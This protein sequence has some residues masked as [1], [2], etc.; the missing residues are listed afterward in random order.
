MTTF[1]IIITILAVLGLV[2]TVLILRGIEQIQSW[3]KSIWQELRSICVN[4]ADT[5]EYTHNHIAP[6]V[7]I[8]SNN[9]LHLIEQA[10]GVA[11]E[12]RIVREGNNHILSRLHPEYQ[13][14]NDCSV[15]SKSLG[16]PNFSY[17]RPFCMDKYDTKL[18]N[19]ATDK[20]ED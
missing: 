9:F 2:A 10:D 20:K 19:K 15:C 4:V 13:I 5:A 11:K 18:S 14:I 12:L 16:C 8:I 3:Q 6:D 1:E 7:E 17:T